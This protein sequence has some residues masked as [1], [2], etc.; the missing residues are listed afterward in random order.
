MMHNLMLHGRGFVIRYNDHT[1]HEGTPLHF[2]E[3][4]AKT[5]GV[6]AMFSSVKR[7]LVDYFVSRH[8]PH[9]RTRMESCRKRMGLWV[10]PDLGSGRDA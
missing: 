10:R 8:T 9:A 5:L 1:E 6:K 7:E 3:F 4:S 2:G